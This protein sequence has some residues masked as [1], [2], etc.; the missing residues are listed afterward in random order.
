MTLVFNILGQ[1]LL[2]VGMLNMLVGAV[3]DVLYCRY[4]WGGGSSQTQYNGVQPPAAPTTHS[5]SVN[6]IYNNDSPSVS[7]TEPVH[8][9][10]EPLLT[11]CDT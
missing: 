3:V 6:P 4:K 5:A 7:L 9:V 10:T 1:E 11:T 2:C 8:L